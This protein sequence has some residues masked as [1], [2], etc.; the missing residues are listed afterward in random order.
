M[1]SGRVF[2]C[3]AQYD[4]S[5]LRMAD[6]TRLEWTSEAAERR[7]VVMLFT[8]GAFRT[9]RLTSPFGLISYSNRRRIRFPRHGDAKT[10]GRT[11]MG[12]LPS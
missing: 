3:K 2:L 6:M 9:F 1:P 10:Y 11:F 4:L 8:A 7:L 12:L 5:M